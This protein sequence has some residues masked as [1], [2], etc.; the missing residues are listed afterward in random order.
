[1]GVETRSVLTRYFARQRWL[2][3]ALFATIFCAAC[4]EIVFPWLLQEAVDATLGASTQLTFSTTVVCMVLTAAGAAALHG[5]GVWI[6][7]RLFSRASADL[8]SILMAQILDRPLGYLQRRHSAEIV[9]R[10]STGVAAFELMATELFSEFPF[11]L[12]VVLG[13]TTMMALTSPALTVAVLLMLCTAGVLTWFTGAKLPGLQR[14]A[15]IRGAS[16]ARVVGDVLA[17]FRVVK[18]FNAEASQQRRFDRLNHDLMFANLAGGKVRAVLTPLWEFAV[19]LAV[20]ATLGYG[21]RLLA[22]GD[23]SVGQLVAFIAYVEM[24]AVPLHRFGDY[25]YQLQTCRGT[26]DRITSLLDDDE[27]SE[28]QLGTRRTGDE[29]G[30][31][32]QNVSFTY[33]GRPC[34]VLKNLSLQISDG[35]SIALIGRNGAGKSTLLDL[36]LKFQSPQTGRILIGDGDLAEWHAGSWRRSVGFAPQD[37][38]MLAGT[39]RDNLALG[40]SKYTDEEISASLAAVTNDDWLAQFPDGLDTQVGEYGHGLSGG[41]RQIVSLARIWLRDPRIVVLDEPTAH[42]DGASLQVVNDAIA[43][44]MVDRTVI[45]VSHNPSTIALASRVAVL[46]QGQVVGEGTREE[47]L[48]QGI[49]ETDGSADDLAAF[50]RTDLAN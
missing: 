17:S 43:S 41:Q 11:S 38:Q 18:A 32:F 21:G 22:S 45:V 29:W 30:I 46:E 35:T 36:L 14:L 40:M 12:L 10:V 7:G 44:L 16:L 3:G 8:R 2:L 24:L 1:M 6:D 20:I 37:A 4:L 15:Q 42:L 5:V 31:T 9:H 48:R 23:I 27:E 34:P 26:I 28:C 39:L 19:V 33:P 47:L 50:S 13:V 49:L 25:Y